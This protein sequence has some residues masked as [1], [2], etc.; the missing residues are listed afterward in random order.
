MQR[1]IL[2]K[3]FSIIS[4]LYSIGHEIIYSASKESYPKVM[5]DK[6]PSNGNK[7]ENYHEYMKSR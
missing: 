2:A 1:P 6:Y 4:P 5:S 3:H 7:G